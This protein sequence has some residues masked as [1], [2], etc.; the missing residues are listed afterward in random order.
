M[1]L[2]RDGVHRILF[3]EVPDAKRD[4]NRLHFDLRPEEGTQA[5]E[6][7]RLRDLG[8]TEVADLRAKYGAGTGWVVLADPKGNEFCILRGEAE[9]AQA[10]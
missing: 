10:Q 2:R 1:I 9:A 7:A 3:I 5:E 8:A 6:L 4:K